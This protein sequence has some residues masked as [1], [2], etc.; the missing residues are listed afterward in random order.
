[1][2]TEKSLEMIDVAKPLIMRAMEICGK[3]SWPAAE[4]KRAVSLGSILLFMPREWRVQSDDPYVNPFS[5]DMVQAVFSAISE[6]VVERKL[7]F[8][9][10]L[11]TTGHVITIGGNSSG[12]TPLGRWEFGIILA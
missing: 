3:T 9:P 10:D 4:G 2:Q 5:M 8:V 1:M 6:L 7:Q 11:V 12:S